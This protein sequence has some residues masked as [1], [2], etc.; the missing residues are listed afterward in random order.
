MTDK[1]APA[2]ALLLV[3]I[4]CVRL[5]VCLG[6]VRVRTLVRHVRLPADSVCEFKAKF[7]MQTRRD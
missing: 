5:F 1:A 7:G 6:R 4:P 3:C 2:S